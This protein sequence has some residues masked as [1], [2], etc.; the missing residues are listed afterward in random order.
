MEK[1]ISVLKREFSGWKK[2]Q[3]IWLIFA[4]AIIL[5]VSMYLGDTAIGIL[6]SMT[7]VTCVIL[8]GIAR[9]AC[10]IAQSAQRK[11]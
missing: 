1:L 2:W 5:G 10:G 6:A 7:G 4:N 3:I 9:F 11:C 8:C